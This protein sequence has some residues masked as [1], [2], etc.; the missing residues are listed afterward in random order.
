MGQNC[1]VSFWIPIDSKRFVVHCVFWVPKSIVWTFGHYSALDSYFT[2]HQMVSSGFQT[3]RLSVVSLLGLGKFCY[4]PEFQY[5]DIELD[6]HRKILG[7]QRI[8]L[9]MHS[10]L[11]TLKTY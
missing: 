9:K 3:S 4:L 8:F 5:L 1:L 6:I 11:G 7:L 10:F 2:N